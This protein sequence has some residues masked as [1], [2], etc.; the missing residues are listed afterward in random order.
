MKYL[1]LLYFAFA[2]VACFDNAIV[3]SASCQQLMSAADCAVGTL[4]GVQ[5]ECSW[6]IK[7]SETRKRDAN[8]DVEEIGKCVNIKEQSIY[9][10]NKYSC[11]VFDAD[12]ETDVGNCKSGDS[13]G[14]G[15]SCHTSTTAPVNIQSNN[16]YIVSKQCINRDMEC[17]NKNSKLFKQN[18]KWGHA[19]E[20][21]YWCPTEKDNVQRKI[22]QGFCVCASSEQNAL[23]MLRSSTKEYKIK[24][25]SRLCKVKE[26][27]ARADLA[28][29]ELEATKVGLKVNLDKQSSRTC[30]R[31]QK[32]QYA[33]KVL[34]RLYNS[35]D[36][37]KQ[38]GTDMCWLRD[39][40][41]DAKGSRPK[42][43]KSSSI[44]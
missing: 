35:K 5:L 15:F 6:C 23:S 36:N 42:S 31:N 25:E 10:G 34:N 27:R 7:A 12:V 11:T 44:F 13:C 4:S 18:C 3:A 1:Y 26:A 8:G 19:R 37:N 29:D 14:N 9:K 32:F 28:K 24:G 30:L 16:V 22:G 41:S 17:I 40:W 43:S 21:M 38:D 20:P 33:T 39:Q 2:I